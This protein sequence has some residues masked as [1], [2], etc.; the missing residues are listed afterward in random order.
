M[1]SYEKGKLHRKVRTQS[2]GPK[3]LLIYGCHVTKGL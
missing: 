1:N 2:D 3:D